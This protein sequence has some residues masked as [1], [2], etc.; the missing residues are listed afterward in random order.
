MKEEPNTPPIARFTFTPGQGNT[1]TKF[2][3]YANGCFDKEDDSSLLMVRWSWDWQYDNIWDTGY[4]AH[5]TE[6]HQYSK[7]GYYM[8]LLE[9]RDTEGLFSRTS[10]TILVSPNVPTVSTDTIININRF[11]AQGGGLVA[12]EGSYR[13]TERGVCWS[14]SRNPTVSDS[15]TFDGDGGGFYSSSIIGLTPCTKYYVRAYATSSV[16]TAYGNEESFVTRSTCLN[17]FLDSRDNQ[18]YKCYKIGTQIWMSENLA[19]LPS[20]NLSNDGSNSQVKYYVYGYEG[21]N[22]ATAK[23]TSNY[24]AYGVLY[25]WVAAKIS[26]PEGWHLPSDEEYKTLEMY[27]GMSESDANRISIRSSGNVGFKLKSI[28]GWD[29]NGNGDNSS[30]FNA[31]AGG[32]NIHDGDF[33]ALGQ[34]ASFWSSSSKISYGWFRGLRNSSDGVVRSY[35]NLNGY[36]VRCLQND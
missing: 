2:T 21:T 34:I 8:I 15:K 13:V 23:A 25:N 28:T 36:S 11:S 22:V 31:L 9:V 33:Q 27:L 6:Q 4:S 32:Q 7:P 1:D 18:T 10:K 35:T 14:T 17:N 5:K 12:S 3:F 26:C 30:G 16:G 29:D 19:Y 20:V 24:E